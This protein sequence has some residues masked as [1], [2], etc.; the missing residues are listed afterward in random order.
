MSALARDG[1]RDVLWLIRRL[2][3]GSEGLVAPFTVFWFPTCYFFTAALT[4]MY[5]HVP[6]LMISKSLGLGN[7]WLQFVTVVTLSLLAHL[8]F[9][10][11][12]LGR[13]LLLGQ[14]SAHGAKPRLG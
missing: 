6:I 3:V 7:H 12:P 5:V 13:K 8:L 11:H 4:I 9:S 14:F 1:I 10:A 2:S